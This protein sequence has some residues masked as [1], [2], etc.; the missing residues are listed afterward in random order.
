[1]YPGRGGGTPHI[2]SEQGGNRGGH[3]TSKFDQTFI[4]GWGQHTNFQTLA[5]G[6]VGGW[7]MIRIMPPHAS[8]FQDRSFKILSQ[9]ENPRWSLVWQYNFRS[10]DLLIC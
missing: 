9:A 5:V 4:L 2:I 7:N 6:R 10:V 3:C 1:M 8:F